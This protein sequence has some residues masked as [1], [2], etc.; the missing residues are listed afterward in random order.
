[1]KANKV[2]QNILTG[3]NYST[4]FVESIIDAVEE[5]SFWISKGFSQMMADY[6]L[7]E[8]ADS[9]NTLVLKDGSLVSLIVLKGSRQIVGEDEFRE[10]TRVISSSLGAYV[11]NGSGHSVQ[12]LFSRDAENTRAQLNG[13]LASS[14]Q[15]AERLGIDISD[16]FD[17]RIDSLAKHCAEET[18]FF[19]L[20]TKVGAISKAEVKRSE[21]MKLAS[22]KKKGGATALLAQ[23]MLL[24]IDGLRDRHRSFVRAF[25]SDINEAG[26][27]AGVLDAHAACREIRKKID[28]EFTSESWKP[29]LPGDK[30]P[31]RFDH[32]TNDRDVSSL[33]YPKLSSQLIPR[34]GRSLDHK[35]F[36]VGGKI[37]SS[38]ILDLG[39][40]DIRYFNELFKRLLSTSIPWR[41]SY[42]IEGGGLHSIALKKA[43]ASVLAVFDSGNKLMVE[44]YNDLRQQ[45]M[46]ANEVDVKFSMVFSTWVSEKD[47]SKLNS[48]VGDLARA[49][50]GW[51]GCEVSETTGDAASAF[52]S[53]SLINGF[54][55]DAPHAAAKLSD[56]VQMLPIT[57]VSS[58][59]D[60][61]SVLFRTKD[62]KAWPY[63]P[64]SSKQSAWI[65]LIFAG[66]GSG[67]SVL[68]N[69]INLALC[70]DPRNTRLPR[71]SIIDI[72]PSSLGLITLLKD[73]LPED[74]KHEATYHRM[75]MTEDCA[76]NPFDTT[77]GCRLPISSHRTFLINFMTLLLTPI[78]KI[79]L[80]V[81]MPELIGLVINET[82]EKLSDNNDAKLYSI[83]IETAIDDFLAGDGYISDK[84]TTWWEI[85]DHLF[86]KK[87]TRLSFSAQK[88]AVP[89]LSDLLYYARNPA[90]ADTFKNELPTLIDSFTRIITSAI[91]EYPIISK[92]TMFDIGESRVI[93]LDLD[94][95]AKTGG[96]SA[97]RQTS[98]MYMLSRFVLA[99]DFYIIEENLREMPKLYLEY[100]RARIK[101]SEED[102]KRLCIDEL[103]RTKNSPSVRSQIETDIREGRKWKVHVALAS[104]DLTDFDDIMVSLSSNIFIMG[105]FDDKDVNDITKRFGL[106]ETARHALIYSTHGPRQGV[107]TTF[108]VNMVTN[109]SP[110]RISQ[111]ITSTIGSIEYW[112][113]STTK[114]DKIIRQ[115]AYDRFGGKLARQLLSKS[116]PWGI[117]KEIERRSELSQS[118]SFSDPENDGLI[119][120]IF[121]DIVDEH[122]AKR[123]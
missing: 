46:Y 48:F 5:V 66:M 1:M 36:Q 20:R 24:A 10:I 13:L 91:R 30:L 43:V 54:K 31:L 107:G 58:P 9:Q 97:D 52:F 12:C 113:F 118:T 123:Q 87:K 41:V 92:P 109:D 3:N 106:S 90:V 85:V 79:S 25:Q 119:S 98:L 94:E 115:M 40:T 56:I 121:K 21:Q 8:T 73:L 22:I 74:R 2:K 26:L 6:V 39:P 32:K 82:Y 114:D 83:G 17:D 18:C 69:T 65:D 88:H 63:Q 47:K 120:G 80:D 61:G 122:L 53:S 16:I 50:E 70:V 57:R 55:S 37:Y 29:L 96:P 59:W 89:V 117:S 103:H 86:K 23:N 101:D 45:V 51:G 81:G 77:L 67:K 64:G 99:K 95:V 76:I 112:A 105:K 34:S 38:V 111:V 7:V 42:L 102:I 100:H 44:A 49:V 27:I 62:G 72:G 110:R 60:S 14:R 84:R 35:A 116:Y 78:G 4:S 11:G 104:Q 68:M 19:A 28:I 71:I 93:S 75:T 108:L 15:S 33:F